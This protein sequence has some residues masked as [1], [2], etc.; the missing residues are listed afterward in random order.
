MAAFGAMI[1]GILQILGKAAEG[2]LIDA[3]IEGA[4]DTLDAVI[5][6]FG[7]GAMR[8]P[9]GLG[10]AD[11]AAHPHPSGVSLATVAFSAVSRSP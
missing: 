4:G 3:V 2:E 10:D 7:F 5:D 8:H 9:G 11:I 1:D 6:P